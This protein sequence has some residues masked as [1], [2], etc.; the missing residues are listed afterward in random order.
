MVGGKKHLHLHLMFA[1]LDDTVE[2]IG[3]T[4]GHGMVNGIYDGDGIVRCCDVS[5][6]YGPES[7]V[8]I[9]SAWEMMGMLISR[10]AG[11][12]RGLLAQIHEIFRIL[13][14]VHHEICF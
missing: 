10:I 11:T 14:G 8:C 6:E 7:G 4:W 2:G 3:I 5:E 1:W 12:V 13:N 9:L